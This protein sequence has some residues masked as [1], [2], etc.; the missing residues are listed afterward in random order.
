M[1]EPILTR[2]LIPYF[3][4]ALLH[5]NSIISASESS[6]EVE[7]PRGPGL[8]S[9][10]TRGNAK[11]QVRK[12]PSLSTFAMPISTP[13]APSIQLINA[14]STLIAQ[15][16]RENRDLLRTLTELM[17][18]TAVR[19]KDTKMPLPNLILIFCPTLQM[20]GALLRVLCE[21]EGIW[22][23]P[24]KGAQNPV[25]LDI[26][27]E[28]ADK[29]EKGDQL[30][31]HNI[32]PATVSR[33]PEDDLDEADHAD[34]ENEP[35]LKSQR[36]IRRAKRASHTL[37]EDANRHVIGSGVLVESDGTSES[38]S[39][40]EGP[41][42]A[43]VHSTAD[44]LRSDLYSPTAPTTSSESLSTPLS[45]ASASPENASIKLVQQG[46]G[47]HEAATVR[48]NQPSGLSSP[49]KGSVRKSMIGRPIPFPNDTASAPNTPVETP[50]HLRLSTYSSSPN[51][52]A[53]PS[54]A[55]GCR[56][57]KASLQGLFPKRS[58]SSLLGRAERQ[59]ATPTSADFETAPQSRVVSSVCPVLELPVSTS[60]IK[61]DMGL[62]LTLGPEA[63]GKGAACDSA[64]V[65]EMSRSSS[66]SSA[67]FYT[68]PTASRLLPSAP[69]MSKQNSSG[70]YSFIDLD[71]SKDKTSE[72]DDWASSVLQAAD[73]SP[74]TYKN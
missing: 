25:V 50:T 59:P 52:G 34:G 44:S 11:P 51:L 31:G 41:L 9:S 5:E 53:P 39:P 43:G 69:S 71:L 45:S 57:S 56:R 63:A 17:R 67:V 28:K 8:P 1:P 23:G 12:A 20:S 27:D 73:A 64:A 60:P 16:P 58:L 14:L 61:L 36:T 35:A 37:S 70:S 29:G 65:D 6:T 18:M 74:I 4:A 24:P 2:N 30:D 15:L 32:V 3:E 19:V 72:A 38:S 33:L 21:S 42:S 22:D 62:G 47:L 54:P 26:K 66:N 55:P 49:S 68:P 46:I 40:N 13:R 7:R 10:P 48:G